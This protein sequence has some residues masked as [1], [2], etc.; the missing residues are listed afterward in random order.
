MLFS[1]APK[2]ESIIKAKEF[3]NANPSLS[4]KGYLRLFIKKYGKKINVDNFT[5]LLVWMFE[6]VDDGE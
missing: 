6:F 3:I 5:K 4:Y 1:I 2:K